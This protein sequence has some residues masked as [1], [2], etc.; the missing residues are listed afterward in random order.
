MHIVVD[1]GT[2][3]ILASALTTHRPCDAAQARG[4]L[5]Q[6][7]HELAL[8]M[9][10]GAYDTA[11]VL[12]AIDA[13]GSGPA[14]QILIPTRRDARTKGL[15]NASSQRDT[16]IRAINPD[17]RKRW[18]HESGSTPRSLVE[19]VISRYKAIIGSMRSRIMPSQMTETALACDTLNNMTQLEMPDGYCIAQKRRGSNAVGYTMSPAT[20]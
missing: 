2:G 5:T 20:R 18:E 19:T 12:A 9:A 14:P 6:M 15:A 17:G 11:S 1:T 10:D 7:D 8:V 16:T 3:D 13:H 4:L